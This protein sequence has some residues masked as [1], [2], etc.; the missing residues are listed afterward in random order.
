[1]VVFGIISS[2]FWK[3]GKNILPNWPWSR[4]YWVNL[5]VKYTSYPRSNV[6]NFHSQ[7]SMDNFTFDKNKAV[8]AVLLISSEVPGIRFHS[9]LKILYFSDLKHL[10]KY[11][12]PI[13]GDRYVV[14]KDGPVASWIY[15]LLKKKIGQEYWHLF[16]VSLWKHVTAK[17]TPDLDYFSETD[18]ECL[19]ESIEENKN[20]GFGKLTEKSHDEAWKNTKRDKK[21]SMDDLI[22]ASGADEEMRK[23]IAQCIEY[24]TYRP[25]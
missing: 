20:L 1:M 23:Y 18:I 13:T 2:V 9:L 4:Y 8:S 15:D 7:F 14:M 12:R 21:I 25:A 10:A 3:T 22:V 5:V 17:S 19:K 16:D 11:G 24:K 6:D